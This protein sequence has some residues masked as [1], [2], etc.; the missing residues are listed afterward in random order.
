MIHFGKGSG[1][2]VD[3]WKGNATPKTDL[4]STDGI[5]ISLKQ[6]GGS[7]LMSG[8]HDE[9]KST[10]RAATE[11]MDDNAP[12]EVEQL[13]NSLGKVL[14]NIEVQGNINSI[15]K[16]LKSFLNKL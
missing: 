8:L 2:M 10:F 14:K 3:W 13:V 16:R 15:A 1:A 4:Y 7:Q 11:Y 5:N 9:T 6:R 12:K